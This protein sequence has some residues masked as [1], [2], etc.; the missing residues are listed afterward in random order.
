MRISDWSSD[1]CSSDLS[2]QERMCSWG[3]SGHDGQLGMEILLTPQ[4]V[5][6][7]AT[8][9]QLVV[10]ADLDDAAAIAREDGIGGDEGTQ[11]GGDDNHRLILWR[12][13]KNVVAVPLT[14]AGSPC[15]CPRATPPRGEL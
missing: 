9:E 2:S 10:L 4:F 1:V 5:I 6:E 13:I 11:P 3:G 8:A 12:S 7:L 15:W 14:F